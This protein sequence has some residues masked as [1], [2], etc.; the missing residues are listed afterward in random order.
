MQIKLNCISAELL[1]AEI[2]NMII[3]YSYN[4][5]LDDTGKDDINKITIYD[6]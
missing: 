3:P 4:D 1:K 5:L 2:T 6:K